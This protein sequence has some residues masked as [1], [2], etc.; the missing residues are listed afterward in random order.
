[1]TTA[2]SST[3][4]LEPGFIARKEK[5]GELPPSS[6]AEMDASLSVLR[7]YKDVWVNMDLAQRIQIL[8]Q[9]LDDL[10]AVA[11]EW[12]S[13]GIV[14]RG[15]RG[16]LVGEAEEWAMFSYV[17]RLVSLLADSLRDIQRYG[18]PQ[19]PGPL[20]T[21]ADGQVVA[22]VFPIR[23]Y[24]R[25]F[26]QGTTAEV[27]MQPGVTIEETIDSQARFY[28][29]E[30]DQGRVCLILG[31]GNTPMGV[32]SDF[33]AKLFIEGQVAAV[34]MNPVND[35][36]GP[37]L[38]KGFREL[39]SRGFLRI[40]YGGAE[41]GCYLCGHPD[42]DE[43]HITGSN[44]TYE[45]ILFGPGEE[46]ARRKA[47]RRPL[48]DKPFSGELGT[49]A[50]VI[51]VPGPWSEKEIQ[52][53]A[54]RLVLWMTANAGFYCL[55]PRVIVQWAGWEQRQ[56]F[57]EAITRTLAREATRKAYY[58]GAFE[59]HARFLAEHPQAQQ[60]GDVGEGCLPWTFIPGVD[61]R[62]VDNICFKNEPF[63][64]L[65]AETAVTAPDFFSYLEKAVQFANETLWGNLNSTLIVHPDC[66]K[67]QPMAMAVDRA[68]A[69]LKTGMVLINQFVAFAYLISST[70][71]GAFPGNDI[72]DIQSGIGV[73]G[74]VLMFDRPQKSVVTGPFT[75]PLDPLTVHSRTINDT[76]RKLVDVQYQPSLA[77]VSSMLW[78]A[79]R[80]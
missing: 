40:V 53:Q 76:C 20:H 3:E 16:N 32:P 47:Q 68:V 38:S 22:P 62:D 49:V 2:T 26:L 69:D 1:M 9:T 13:A 7:A 14:A 23:R 41:E 63:C 52:T 34:K 59:R 4:I 28:H 11:D 43:V 42:V 12:W 60:F 37:V 25:L 33:L 74:N 10:H 79:V 46:G 50:P 36:L 56:E 29:E 15:L 45:A 54:D 8:D 18:R 30:A 17:L 58:P 27:W 39:I 61:A 55:T 71:W 51:I 21:R 24:D 80:S 65:L 48:L 77:N 64:G 66:L 5:G 73:T 67:K 35:Y 19:L 31:A 6:R 70:T 75:L 57:N 44:R 78:S 72:D